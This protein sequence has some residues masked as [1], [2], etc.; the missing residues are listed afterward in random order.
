MNSPTC[1][2]VAL[3]YRNDK[4]ILGVEADIWELWW[5]ILKLRW[6]LW[7]SHA[8]CVRSQ[9][10]SFQDIDEMS[11]ALFLG[12]ASRSLLQLLLHH[13]GNCYGPNSFQVVRTRFEWNLCLNIQCLDASGKEGMVSITTIWRTKAT[14]WPRPLDPEAY[15]REWPPDYLPKPPSVDSFL[16]SPLFLWIRS[17]FPP[18]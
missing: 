9:N 13:R 16:S 5:F 17:F 15:I 12:W 1:G 14:A 10:W 4:H 18:K 11:K 7:P 3:S 2:L 6:M 8:T